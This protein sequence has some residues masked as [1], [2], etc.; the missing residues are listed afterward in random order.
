MS[1]DTQDIT[2]IAVTL[3]Q[4]AQ[5]YNE[6]AQN[7]FDIFYNPEPKDITLKFFDLDGII[8]T[9]TLANRAKDMKFVMNGEG[10]PNGQRY[11]EDVEDQVLPVNTV[12]AKRGSIY[13]DLYK[14]ELWIKQ[15]DDS[16]ND[17]LRVMSLLEVYKKGKGNPNDNEYKNY[18]ALGDM[19]VD[20]ETGNLYLKQEL[21]GDDTWKLAGAGGAATKQELDDVYEEL[22]ARIKVTEDEIAAGVV[23]KSGAP[24]VISSQKTFRDIVTFEKVIMGTAY[25]ALSADIAEFYEADEY[26]EPGT[27][28]Q[29]GGDKEITKAVDEVNAVVSTNPAYILNDNKGM[30]YP[31]LIALSGRIPVRIKGPVHKFDKIILSEENGVAIAIDKNSNSC[32]NVIGRALEE[33]LHDEDK[34]VECVVKLEL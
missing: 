26:I 22:L 8:Q 33:N 17:W 9:Y 3:S 4:L 10:Q 34:L 23:H 24:E 32:Y 19:Y 7:W 28:V 12:V 18:G 15:S 6:L 31:T 29:F 16:Y 20:S 14:G 1:V 11:I 13:L 30:K 25:R 21:I 2:Q 27:L 5:N